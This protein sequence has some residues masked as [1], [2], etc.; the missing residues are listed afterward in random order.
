MEISWVA[1]CI[2]FMGSE[3]E[4]VTVLEQWRVLSGQHGYM[5]VVG[6]KV[7][8]HALVI[9]MLELNNHS[10]MEMKTR[11]SQKKILEISIHKKNTRTFWIKIQ[12]MWQKG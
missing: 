3:N 10:Q 12:P 1:N 11:T 6:Q 7:N 9:C 4:V 5:E 2:L 8:N